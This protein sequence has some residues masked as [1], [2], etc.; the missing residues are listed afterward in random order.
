MCQKES[1]Q[2]ENEALDFA[3]YVVASALSLSSVDS[4]DP[5]QQC[6]GGCLGG[7]HALFAG[8]AAAGSVT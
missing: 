8:L 1:R 2:I 7:A 5:R 4:C 3:L 6:F